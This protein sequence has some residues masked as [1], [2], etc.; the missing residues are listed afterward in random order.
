MH[1][2][3]PHLLFLFLAHGVLLKYSCTVVIIVHIVIWSPSPWMW[4]P[5]GGECLNIFRKQKRG[6]PYCRNC[7]FGWQI[8]DK[9]NLT[10]PHPPALFHPTPL[11]SSR[12]VCSLFNPSTQLKVPLLAHSWP[13]QTDSFA[14]ELA[15]SFLLPAV[16]DFEV[17]GGWLWINPPGSSLKSRTLSFNSLEG[18]FYASWPWIIW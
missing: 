5:I 7:S 3:D 8:V 14:V 6:Q 2:N 15:A 1:L 16:I 4:N 18:L 11:Y 13:S 12:T 17:G 9:R 10:W